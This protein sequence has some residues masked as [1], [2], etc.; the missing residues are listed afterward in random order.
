MT[1]AGP[2]SAPPVSIKSSPH[3][4]ALAT[5]HV[6]LDAKKHLNRFPGD[7]PERHRQATAMIASMDDG[8]G[9]IRAELEKLDLTKNGIMEESEI[10]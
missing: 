8:V 9:A 1:T 7:M 5:P 3:L 2:T 6:P 4:D 10:R